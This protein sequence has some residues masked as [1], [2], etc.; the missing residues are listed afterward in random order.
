MLAKKEFKVLYEYTQE[1]AA[2]QQLQPSTPAKANA[3]KTQKPTKRPTANFTTIKAEVDLYAA[4]RD[5]RTYGKQANTVIIHP[6]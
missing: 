5:N 2:P 3:G 6:L 4:M 1:N